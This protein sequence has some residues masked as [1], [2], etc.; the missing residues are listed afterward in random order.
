[1]ALIRAQGV[2]EARFRTYANKKSPPCAYCV[3]DTTATAAHVVPQSFRIAALLT[4]N[5]TERVTF[6]LSRAADAAHLFSS[7]EASS[8]TVPTAFRLTNKRLKTVDCDIFHTLVIFEQ[9]NSTLFDLNS[10]Q[11]GKKTHQLRKL[12]SGCVGC[13]LICSFNTIGKNAFPRG[14]IIK[15]RTKDLRIPLFY[16]YVTT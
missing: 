12:Y 14:S 2:H 7:T 16:I 9:V 8:S 10:V 6:G 3:D 5:Q 13:P 1:M 4:A 11:K 15:T